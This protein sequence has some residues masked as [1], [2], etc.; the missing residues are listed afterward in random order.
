MSSRGTAIDRRPSEKPRRLR[1]TFRTVRP[2]SGNM[3]NKA[4]HSMLALC[5]LAACPAASALQSA[6]TPLYLAGP[7]IPVEQRVDSLIASMTPEEKASQLGNA[8]AAIPRLQ[9]PRYNW[10]NEGLHGV[11]RAGV[12]T[13]FPQAIGLAATFDVPL[14]HQVG[15][16]I[17]RTDRSQLGRATPTVAPLALAPLASPGLGSPLFPIRGRARARGAEGLIAPADHRVTFARRAFQTEPVENP[18]RAPAIAD[19]SRRLY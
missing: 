8:A 17:C 13:V 16:V 10:W 14:M 4:F 1:Y 2:L 11:A 3:N 15:D 19:Q 7:Q 9:V 12:A 5:C 18:H 6:D